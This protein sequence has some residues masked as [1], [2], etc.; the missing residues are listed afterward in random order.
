MLCHAEWSIHLCTILRHL[1]GT[2]K[3]RYKYFPLIESWI[4]YLIISWDCCIM[5]LIFSHLFLTLA[6]T[7]TVAHQYLWIFHLL[8]CCYNKIYE[9]RP[10]IKNIV[11]G[12][13]IL[14]V[15][16]SKNMIPA[17]GIWWKQTWCLIAKNIT[18]EVGLVC[19][20]KFFSLSTYKA[21][22]SRAICEGKGEFMISFNPNNISKS[23][24]STPR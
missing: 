12:L 17:H 6:F 24:W 23:H 10:F 21:Q 20:F 9:T 3:V 18:F 13:R 11:W 22:S 4:C 19:Y 8:L 16:K 2:V 1:W 5:C 7:Y 15:G 14:Q